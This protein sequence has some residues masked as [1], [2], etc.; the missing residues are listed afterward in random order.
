MI[1][2]DSALQ[3]K[4][5]AMY[6]R[7]AGMEVDILTDPMEVLPA[8]V[9]NHPELILMD[10]Y[11]PDCT[12]LE[13]AKV[14]RQMDTML[15]IPIV[16]L[17]SETDREKQLAAIGLGGD[18][19]LSKPIKPEFL[20]SAV[21]SRIERYRKL[22]SLMIH[23]SLTGLLNH[24]T[25]EERIIQEM[26]RARR[27]NSR[28]T[29]AMIDLDRF[30]QINDSYGHSTGDRV[31]R[32]LARLLKQRLRKSDIIGRFGGEE[33][34]VIMPDTSAEHA[35]DVMNELRE[36]FSQI[37]YYSGDEQFNVTF[38]CG[39]AEFPA[40]DTLQLL[41]DTADQALYKAKGLGR[42]QSILAEN[43]QDIE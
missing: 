23:D 21:A 1:V 35:L 31:L 28:M 8:L 37:Y 39:I 12:G 36:R 5:S 22:R 9:N 10:I 17:S 13:L 14:I 33:F 15:S 40:C 30:K 41:K 27:Q 4:L 38:S 20:I 7:R 42:N 3:A 32:S 24:L 29:F 6:L 25:T 43:K 16:F 2:D 18:D 19:F 11:M 34:A 26:A